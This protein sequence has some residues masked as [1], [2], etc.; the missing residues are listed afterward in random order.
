MPSLVEQV[1]IHFYKLYIH[2]LFLQS[3]TKVYKEN[4]PSSY[5]LVL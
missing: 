5:K 3:M 2:I 1:L 4:H